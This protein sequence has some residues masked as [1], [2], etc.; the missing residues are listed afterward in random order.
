MY[1]IEGTIYIEKTDLC[2]DCKYFNGEGTCPLLGALALDVVSLEDDV[3]VSTCG[4][5]TQKT[6]LRVVKGDSDETI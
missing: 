4:M 6:K 1:D 3:T 5:Y 2:F